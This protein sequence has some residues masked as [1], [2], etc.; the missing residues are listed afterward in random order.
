MYLFRSKLNTYASLFRA[1]SELALLQNTLGLFSIEKKSLH[2][3]YLLEPIDYVG[4][5]SWLIR[6]CA[7]LNS[8]IVYLLSIYIKELESNW[9]FENFDTC[10]L[11]VYN[12]GKKCYIVDIHE[13]FMS[14]LKSIS[15][16]YKNI[17][18]SNLPVW[19]FNSPKRRSLACL[20]VFTC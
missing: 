4:V 7:L 11:W 16:E 8:C 5:L 19:K 6:M 17:M 10:F 2:I 14:H 1:S 20:L 3:I 12:W 13:A 15:P 18:E 9:N